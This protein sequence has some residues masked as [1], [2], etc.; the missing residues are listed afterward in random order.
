MKLK[1]ITLENGVDM[2]F[3]PIAIVTYKVIDDMRGY[4][5]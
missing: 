2:P 1:T 4:E 3:N 5:C